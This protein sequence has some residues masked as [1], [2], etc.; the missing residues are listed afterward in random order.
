MKII[1][2]L[3]IF[4]LILL[5]FLPVMLFSHDKCFKDMKNKGHVHDGKCCGC[6]GGDWKTDYLS[7]MCCDCKHLELTISN[8]N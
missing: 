5:P 7:E 4:A 1:E 6:Y 8:L 2:C 3:I